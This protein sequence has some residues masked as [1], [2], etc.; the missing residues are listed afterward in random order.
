M[1][2]DI[3]NFQSS[4]FF[5]MMLLTAGLVL[6]KKLAM[7]LVFEWFSIV[8][9]SSALER[10]GFNWRDFASNFNSA[11]LRHFNVSLRS[12]SNDTWNKLKQDVSKIHQLIE[13]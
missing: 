1:I 13:I 6:E 2:F 3:I 4:D 11:A 12:V 7:L 5:K 8:E 10:L 9:M